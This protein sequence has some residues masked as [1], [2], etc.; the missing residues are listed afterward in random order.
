MSNQLQAFQNSEFDLDAYDKLLK[1]PDTL[2]TVLQKLKSVREEKS[3]I[4]ADLKRYKRLAARS[5][6]Y[7]STI[8]AC[9]VMDKDTD[10]FSWRLLRAASLD[11][12]R[13][14]YKVP[15]PGYDNGINVYPREAWYQ[16]Y[17][18]AAKR[19]FEAG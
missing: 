12:G 15:S 4:E 5:Q 14:P 6:E 18:D 8:R 17:P 10:D 16:V 13:P 19:L 3:L 7:A 11:V 2:I 9:Q 1:N